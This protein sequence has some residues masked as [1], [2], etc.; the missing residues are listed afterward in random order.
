[1]T[2]FFNNFSNPLLIREL[3]QFVRN[4]FIIVLINFYVLALVMACLFVFAIDVGTLST[5]L[6]GKNL[7]LAL[8]NFVF[9]ASFLTIIIKTAW[10]TAND[11]CNEDLMFYSTMKPSTIVLGKILSGA[12]LTLLLMSITMPFVTLAYM[13]RGIGLDVVLIIMC[14]IFIIVQILNAFAIFVAS[15]SKLKISAYVSIFIVTIASFCMYCFLIPVCASLIYNDN[16][17]YMNEVLRIAFFLESIFLALFICGSIAMFSPPTSNRILPVR[18]LLT[19]ILLIAIVYAF[20]GDFF[21][22]LSW[23]EDLLI[24]E[25]V[26]FVILPFI[27]LSIACERDQWSIRIRRNLPK[28]LLLR[29]ILFPFYTG[30]ACGIVW[31]FLILLTLCFLEL[32]F[33]NDSISPILFRSFF[34][35]HHGY[36]QIH[37]ILGIL[38]FT[39][40]YS[41]T[42]MLIR[43]AFFKKLDTYFV[44]LIVLLMLLT[45]TL[46]SMLCYFLVSILAN[47]SSYLVHDPFGEYASSFYS[48][49]NPF[50]DLSEGNE[51]FKFPRNIGVMFWFF[52]LLIPLARWYANRLKN[53]NPNI[54][55]LLTYEEAREIIKNTELQ[56]KEK[57]IS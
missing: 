53:F 16:S 3:R 55:E 5:G 38:F 44:I 54:Q 26:S 15:S 56:P 32:I 20:W 37:V 13:L 30:A 29:I 41:V 10:E 11:K 22:A 4:K 17:S 34:G 57:K 39:F 14:E 21:P 24:V 42:A 36:M 6:K 23:H 7:L 28:S 50:C 45:F 8:T 19:I 12:I 52:V 43:S 47:D 2:Q 25:V 48:A 1:M 49:L 40:N 9:I 51:Y 33:I 27:V 46:G 31:F 18:V 35:I